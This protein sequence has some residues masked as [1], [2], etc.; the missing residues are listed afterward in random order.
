LRSA[1]SE[2]INILVAP[3]DWG[4]G[5][6]TRCIPIIDQL[7]T[8]NCR[9]WLAGDGTGFRVLQK[10]FP[11][12]PVFSLKGYRVFYQKA[13]RNFSVNILSQLP[14]LMRTVRHEQ[15]WLEKFITAHGIDVVISDNRFGL[16][17]SKAYTVFITHQLSIKTGL[18]TWADHLARRINYYFIKKFNECWIPD[19]Q[20]E[21]NL[22]GELSHPSVLP[23]N[24][25]YIGTLSRFKKQDLPQQ[26][27]LLVILSGP[28]PARTEFE[29]RLL[30]ELAD[31]KGTVLFVRGTDSPLSHEMHHASIVNLMTSASLNEALNASEWVICRSGYTSVMDLVKLQKKAILVPTP[32]QP[33]QEYLAQVLQR[34]G[35]FYCI[36]EK[37]FILAPVLKQA[38]VFPYRFE[39]LAGSASYEE[40][41]KELLEKVRKRLQK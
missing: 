34:K 13:K 2:T 18:G 21:N 5:H 16:Y 19:Y 25:R 10:E 28:E 11:Q 3:L 31:F 27:D 36:P 22:A 8:Y 1:G 7:L 30:K 12:L 38:A 35:I 33:E 4:M 20:G 9:I 41:I 17:S 14:R 15:K 40:H 39:R 29:N 24:T 37:D 6:V 23:L 26:Y 32:G